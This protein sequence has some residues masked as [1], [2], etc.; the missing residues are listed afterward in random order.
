MGSAFVLYLL[1]DGLR[2][3]FFQLTADSIA[4]IFGVEADSSKLCRFRDSV[5]CSHSYH[6]HCAVPICAC[7]AFALSMMVLAVVHVLRSSRS[8]ICFS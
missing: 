3:W 8:L 4:F 2:F 7:K 5:F 6:L 1:D